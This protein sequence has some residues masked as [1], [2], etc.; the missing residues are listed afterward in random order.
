MRKASVWRI[1]IVP[2]SSN[3]HAYLMIAGIPLARR[4]FTKTAELPVTYQEV[5]IQLK[6][7]HQS[8]F[9]CLV[10]RMVDPKG[11]LTDSFLKHLDEEA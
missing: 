6:W 9:T 4:I 10:S 3:L 11:L 5:C 8:Q 7:L 2:I 1:I